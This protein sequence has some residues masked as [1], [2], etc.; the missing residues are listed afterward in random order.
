[1]V[2]KYYDVAELITTGWTY[3]EKYACRGN[4]HVHAMATVDD[5]PLAFKLIPFENL[6]RADIY[7]HIFQEVAKDVDELRHLFVRQ[8]VGYA[9]SREQYELHVMLD[10]K[11]KE[12]QN[13]LNWDGE[14]DNETNTTE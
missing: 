14:L 10:E 4:L 2:K 1:M 11:L 9:D 6:V 13:K 5:K 3:E 12:M 7:N 8:M